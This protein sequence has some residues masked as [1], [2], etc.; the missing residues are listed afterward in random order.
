MKQ[1]KNKSTHKRKK[2]YT[3]RRKR[4]MLTEEQTMVSK[5]TTRG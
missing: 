5:F 3:P 1:F 4:P 2:S